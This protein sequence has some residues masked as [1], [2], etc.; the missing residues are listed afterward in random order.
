MNHAAAVR[1]AECAGNVPGDL[2]R[3]VEGKLSLSPQPGAERLPVDAGHD[4]VEQAVRDTGVEHGNDA[5][6]LQLG[7]EGDLT[8]EALGAH[9]RA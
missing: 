9:S 3:L 4:V 7:G 6:V 2:D 8:Q 5:R 1:V